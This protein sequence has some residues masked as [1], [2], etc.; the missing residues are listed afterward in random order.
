[1]KGQE[2]ILQAIATCSSQQREET[3]HLSIV[4]SPDPELLGKM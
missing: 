1:M 4:H 3:I 2:M